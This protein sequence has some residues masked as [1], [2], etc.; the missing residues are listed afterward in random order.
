[1]I[2][3]HN[4]VSTS[5]HHIKDK[6]NVTYEDSTR[7]IWRLISCTEEERDK[8]IDHLLPEVLGEPEQCEHLVDG[9]EREGDFEFL[10]DL[11]HAAELLDV[12]G[13]VSSQLGR[14]DV[15]PKVFSF[16]EAYSATRIC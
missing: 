9:H 14:K 10:D 5:P 3:R 11:E 13:E 7:D 8:R 12:G 1:M 4:R 2:T 6:R 16:S 15:G